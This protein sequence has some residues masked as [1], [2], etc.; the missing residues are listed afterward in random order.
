MRNGGAGGNFDWVGWNIR[1]IPEK[2]RMALRPGGIM[3]WRDEKLS[4]NVRE[5]DQPR[6]IRK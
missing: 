1:H 5:I 4:R 6:K 2:R 3:G